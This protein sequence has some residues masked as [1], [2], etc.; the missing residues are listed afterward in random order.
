[1]TTSTDKYIALIPSEN[2]SAPNFVAAVQALVQG[3]VDCN[4][5][6]QAVMV[7]F[8]LDTATGDQLDCVGKWVGVTRYVP[9][10]IT[11]VFFAFDTANLGWDQGAWFGPYDSSAGLTRLPDDSYRLLLRAKISAN[12]WDGTMGSLVTILGL[13]FTD[14]LTTTY[15]LDNQDMTMTVGMIGNPPSIINM[16]LLTGG[17]LIPKPSGVHI[18]YAG[19]S[20]SA[21]FGFDS[22]TSLVAGYDV[23]VWTT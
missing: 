19:V 20:P 18:N 21:I 13:I 23:G 15:I 2:Q 14:P 9:I 7:A 5:T 10:P 11:G 16:A 12:H 17:Y 4:N 3:F 6:N 22:S 1:M 8:D